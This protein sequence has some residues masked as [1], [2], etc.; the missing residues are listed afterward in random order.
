MFG[1][2]RRDSEA[3]KLRED[4]LKFKPRIYSSINETGRVWVLC[5]MSGDIRARGWSIHASWYEAMTATA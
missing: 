1:A 4:G 5:W 2:R 3:T